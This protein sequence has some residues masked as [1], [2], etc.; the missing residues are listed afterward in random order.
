[1]RRFLT[2]I[3]SAG[4]MVGA[5]AMPVAAVGPPCSHVVNENSDGTASSTAAYFGDEDRVIGRFFLEKESCKQVT[6]TLWVLDDEGDTDPI[7]Y[8]SVVG[9]GSADFVIIEV[10]G[11]ETT[12]GD[13]CVYV[14]TTIGKQKTA[15]RGPD[16]GCN[17]LLDDGTSP[18]GGKG[19]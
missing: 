5:M 10:F 13:A 18:G 9:D 4:L 17:V 7:A 14:T 1:M 8:G 16:E 3:I 11:V 15:D 19:F 2:A 12:D 6:Y